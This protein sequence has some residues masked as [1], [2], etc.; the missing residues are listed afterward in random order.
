M[1]GGLDV[2]VDGPVVRVV[3]D[4]GEANLLTT[5]MCERLTGLLTSPPPQAHV[6]RLAAR[7]PSFCLGRERRAETAQ[8]LRVEVTALVELNRAL[9]RSRLVTV[10]EVHGDAAGFGVGLAALC[11]V[12]IA[13]PSA[14]FWFPE[15]EIG[16]APAVVL[17]WLPRLVGPK[18]AFDLT[19]TARRIGA[20]E[21]LGLGLLTAVAPTDPAL[22]ATVDDYVATLRKYPAAVHAQIAGFLE[23]SAGLTQYQAEA[24]ATEKLILASLAGRDE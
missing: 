23:A 5:A 3:I 2:A 6:L 12:S 10:A 1:T 7:G 13:A 22:E 24:L 20:T 19:A 17:A 9:R 15:V 18:R 21:A 16:L 4:R 8:G 14:R 11:Q